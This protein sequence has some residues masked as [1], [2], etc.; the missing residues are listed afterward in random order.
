M[1]NTFQ[2]KIDNDD[3]GGSVCLEFQLASSSGDHQLH[4][5]LG[6]DN[7]LNRN[8]A[9]LDVCQANSGHQKRTRR[10]LTHDR[11]IADEA[12][13]GF[14]VSGK[15]S[16]TSPPDSDGQKGATIR[17]VGTLKSTVINAVLKY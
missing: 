17:L 8:Y 16:Y 10:V 3:W 5:V 7:R 15:H 1:S 12:V 6:P 11:R 2:R 14:F 13:A 4:I 9:Y